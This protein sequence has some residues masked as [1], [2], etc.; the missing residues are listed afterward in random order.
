[1]KAQCASLR[2]RVADLERV[3]EQVASEFPDDNIAY[4]GV[5]SFIRSLWTVSH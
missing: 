1:M 2:E 3:L 5:A 4:K